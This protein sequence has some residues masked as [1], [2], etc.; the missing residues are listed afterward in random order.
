ML[1]E[2]FKKNKITSLFI[3][4]FFSFALIKFFSIFFYAVNNFSV[5]YVLLYSFLFFF[6]Y[7]VFKIRF[8]KGLN[9]LQYTICNIL[10][11]V[12]ITIFFYGYYRLIML[13]NDFFNF[14]LFIGI[15]ISNL[16]VGSLLFLLT[17]IRR[18]K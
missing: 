18:A 10:F 7:F 8:S 6:Y 3:W 11:V 9:Y 17:L 12:L 2:L 1:S 16:V 15:L 4:S 14:N 5:Y 13:D